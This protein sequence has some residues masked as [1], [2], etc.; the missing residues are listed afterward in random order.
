M[1][2]GWN[3]ESGPW[4][5]GRR[6]VKTITSSWWVNQLCICSEASVYVSAKSLQSCPILCDPMDRS[7]P[8]SSVHG[9]LQARILGWVAMPSSRGSS[10]PRDQTCVSCISFTAGRF[11]TAEPSG[12]PNEA[13]I[14]YQG[15]WG[16]LV[17]AQLVRSTGNNLDLWLVSEVQGEGHKNRHP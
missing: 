17:Y 14:K 4:F 11:F 12:K 15:S 5:P 7:L 13:S 1:T 10:Q 6:E 8:G 16:P 2:G 3:L 9:I